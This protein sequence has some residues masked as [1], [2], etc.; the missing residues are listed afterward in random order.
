MSEMPAL[1]PAV[2]PVREVT[3]LARP[4]GL[5]VPVTFDGGLWAFCETG[6]ADAGVALDSERVARYLLTG[7]VRA[8]RRAGG[9][10][11]AVLPYRMALGALEISLAARIDASGIFV[12]DRQPDLERVFPLR[13]AG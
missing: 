11:P 5:L 12:S 6:A 9:S 4:L 8:L 7:L 13:A 10:P 3:L 1:P 2:L